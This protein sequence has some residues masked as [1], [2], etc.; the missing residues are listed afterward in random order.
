[1]LKEHGVADSSGTPV[2]QQ[3]PF[4]LAFPLSPTANCL[5][6]NHRLKPLPKAL[7][8]VLFWV[9]DDS[10]PYDRA[11]GDFHYPD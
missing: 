11:A 1:L 2:T 4:T 10:Y 6:A 5:S 7:A 3:T 9:A 8:D